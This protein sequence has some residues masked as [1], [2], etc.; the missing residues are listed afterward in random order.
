MTDRHDEPRDAHELADRVSELG[1]TTEDALEEISG[2]NASLE[3]RL[4]GDDLGHDQGRTGDDG[5]GDSEV[6]R[7]EGAPGQG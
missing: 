6:S 3:E 5:T 4:P 2:R 1:D 7:A